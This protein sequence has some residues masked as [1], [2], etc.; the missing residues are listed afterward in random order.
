MKHLLPGPDTF[1]LASNDLQLFYVKDPIQPDWHVA[2]RTRPRDLFDMGNHMEDDIAAPQNLE[3]LLV[4]DE[5]VQ[6]RTDMHVI[7]V[8]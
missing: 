6:V 4:A 8:D 7:M 5:D 1:T 2:V 3:S